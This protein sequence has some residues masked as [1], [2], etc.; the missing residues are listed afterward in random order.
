MAQIV[1]ETVSTES[2]QPV[3][4]DTPTEDARVSRARARARSVRGFYVHVGV[5]LIVNVSVFIANAVMV[6]V[7][8]GQNWFFQWLLLAWGIAVVINAFVVYTDRFLGPEW[9]ERKVREYLTKQ[10]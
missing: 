6:M 2:A 1:K 10:G 8:S 5:Y 4:P 9:E 3:A 7:N